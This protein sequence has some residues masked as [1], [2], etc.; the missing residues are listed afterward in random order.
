MSSLPGD[1]CLVGSMGVVW[2]VDGLERN[3]DTV[4]HGEAQWEQKNLPHP[5][6]PLD[7]LAEKSPEGFSR[8]VW[9]H[10]RN[11]LGTSFWI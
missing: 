8:G 6:V 7:C 3:V 5:W 1:S 4:V 9:A 10:C 11:Y 2:L